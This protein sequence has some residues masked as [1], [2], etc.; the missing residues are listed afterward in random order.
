MCIGFISRY[1][2][3]SLDSKLFDFVVKACG[4]VLAALGLV[5]SCLGTSLA[6]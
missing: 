3:C 4:G 5:G 2:K 1:F 6:W